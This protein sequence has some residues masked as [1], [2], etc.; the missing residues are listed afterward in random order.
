VVEFEPTVV[1]ILPRAWSK[2]PFLAASC[3]ACA[4]G[5]VADEDDADCAVEGETGRRAAVFTFGFFRTTAVCFGGATSTLG[6]VVLLFPD[7][8]VPGL[9]LCASAALSSAKSSSAEPDNKAA[10]DERIMA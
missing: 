5:C 6:S 10:L 8:L 7:A 4:E 2:T 1:K 3:A 9:A